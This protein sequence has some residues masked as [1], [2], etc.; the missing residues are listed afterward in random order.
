MLKEIKELRITCENQSN[1]IFSLKKGNKQ[2][3][4][5]KDLIQTHSLYS[6]P[7]SYNTTTKLERLSAYQV[8][9]KRHEKSPNNFNILKFS[10]DSN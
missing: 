6:S 2:N 1:E 7:A 10:N 9:K 4:S 8:Q 3:Y 5:S